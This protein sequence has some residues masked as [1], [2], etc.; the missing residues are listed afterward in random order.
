MSKQFS[1]IAFILITFSLKS[2]MAQGSPSPSTP[3]VVYKL[4]FGFE[5]KKIKSLKV[6][7]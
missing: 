4:P 5:T 7:V 2:S 1:M 6:G 3:K